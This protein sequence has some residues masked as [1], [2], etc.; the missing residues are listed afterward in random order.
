MSKK[1]IYS[2]L[3]LVVLAGGFGVQRVTATMATYEG[4]AP[5]GKL[6]G[7][8]AVLQSANLIP[9]GDCAS[10]KQ[11][12]CANTQACTYYDAASKM[13]KKGNCKTVANACGCYPAP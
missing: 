7:L 11:G 6:T 4:F 5:C 10:T 12:P 8:A 1:K 3:A 13:D 9:K 2:V